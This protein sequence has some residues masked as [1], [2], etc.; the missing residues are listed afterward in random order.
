MIRLYESLKRY[1]K[2]VLFLCDLVLWNVAFYLS[3][4]IIRSSLSLRGHEQQF[5]PCLLALN[6]CFSV[7]CLLFKLYDNI[8]RYA[9]IE[10]F[11]YAGIACICSNFA[12]FVV[13]LMMKVNLGFRIYVL[14]TLLSSFLLLLF[15]FVYRLNKILEKRTFGE[16]SYRRMLI[17][18]GG[19][20]AVS[21]LREISKS[22]ENEYL[23]ICIVDDDRE[24]IGRRISGV[25]V[26]GSTYEIPEICEKFDIEVILFS[27]YSISPEDKKR[28]LD[29]CAKTNVEVRIVPSIYDLVTANLSME[30]KIR[31]VEV[32][33]LLGREPVVFDTRKYGK[34]LHNQTVLVT[35]GGGSIGSELCRQIAELAP[36]NLIIL[37]IYENNAYNIQQELRRTHGD[38]LNFEVQI[39][40]VRD[41]DKLDLLFAEKH[42][43]VVFHA[44]A[45][46]HV[47]LM[48]ANP[49]EAV[50]NNVF[51]TLNLIQLADRYHV[52][53]FV[54][55]S[56]DKAV[57]PTNVMGA[58]KRI[59]EMLVQSMDKQS[60]TEFATVRFG[61]V[62]GSNGSVI[63]LFQQQI[64]NGGPVTVTHPDI[65]R[66]FMTIPEAVSLVLTAGGLA[67]GGEIFILD[68]GEPVKIKDLAENLIRLSGFVPGK[69]IQIEY[70]GLRPGE[71]L[72]EELLMDEEGLKS[73]EN[74]KIHIGK[75]I[76]LDADRLSEELRTL[77]EDAEHNDKE[78]V[79]AMLAK[80]VPTYKRTTNGHDAFCGK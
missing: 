31:R 24:K 12:F 15:R 21:I 54:Q 25:K 68:M 72:Y 55:I 51:G 62:L 46:K 52:K 61:N 58:T 36:K 76:D 14:M 44:A 23:P 20:A 1:R 32:E 65:I 66:Y 67:A 60:A 27:I 37:D 2:H 33:D 53:K 63:P 5:V 56:T 38:C 4:A 69:D 26:Q 48:E 70:T 73:T 3:Y 47:P 40:S 7:I 64:K 39:A 75:P 43:D 42:I 41:R 18:G 29:I 57:N 28:I 59:C 10:D 19:E 49:E 77:Y 8:W 71:K 80:I 11:V 79:V 13:T 45:H 30:K 17:V 22:A 6:L 78:K 9:D 16:G 74:K 34:Y 35:G 50:K